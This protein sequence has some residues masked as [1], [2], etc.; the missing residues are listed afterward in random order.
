MRR[1]ELSSNK[2]SDLVQFQ[3]TRYVN[4]KKE[5]LFFLWH[6]KMP[7]PKEMEDL[8]TVVEIHEKVIK[9][10]EIEIINKMKQ[11]KQL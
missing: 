10:L 11:L 7:N 1:C 9:K 3:I 4:Y 5:F 8:E 6:I 2:W